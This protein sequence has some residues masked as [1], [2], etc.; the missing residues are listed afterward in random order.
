MLVKENKSCGK[1]QELLGLIR[2]ME[3]NYTQA[4]EFYE[5][6]FSLSNRKSAAMGYRLAYNYLKAKRYIDCL[7][8][9]RQVTEVHPN[10]VAIKTDIEE[11]AILAIR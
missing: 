2:E 4:S 9:C 6:A 10:Y 11:K 3:N 7:E 8:V 1:A 5:K